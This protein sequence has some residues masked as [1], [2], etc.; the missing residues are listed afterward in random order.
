[1]AIRSSEAT[2]VESEDILARAAPVRRN[3][4]LATLCLEPGLRR[5]WS[6]AMVCVRSRLWPTPHGVKTRAHVV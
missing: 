5:G 4:G 3:L 6:D 1:M 2:A